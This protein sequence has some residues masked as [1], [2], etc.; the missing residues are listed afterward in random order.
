MGNLVAD[1]ALWAGGQALDPFDTGNIYPN[2]PADLALIALA[3]RMGP[4][5]INDDLT[6]DATTQGAVSYTQGVQRGGLREPHRHGHRHRPVHP[7]RAGTAVEDEGNRPHLRALRRVAQRAVHLRRRG[8]AGNR[9][10]PADVLIDG[11]PLDPHATY[12]LATTAYTLIGADDYPALLNH[13]QPVR[14]TRDFESFVA[15]VQSQSVLTPAPLGRVTARAATSLR[16][17]TSRRLLAAAPTRATRTA[18]RGWP[19]PARTAAGGALLS[20]PRACGGDRRV[21]SRAAVWH[22]ARRR[23]RPSPGGR[24]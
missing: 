7:R 14:H 13:T 4:S 6:L 24:P 22:G 20:G 16:A 11:T 9:V 21:R 15:Y 2:V 8:S 18:P 12:R 19:P 17:G 1:W 5:V 3:P 23:D 10:A